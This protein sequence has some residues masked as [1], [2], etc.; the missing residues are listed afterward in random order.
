M[1][2]GG[3]RAGAGRPSKPLVDKILERNPGK[4]PLTVLECPDTYKEETLFI[5]PESLSEQGKEIFN[6][7]FEWLI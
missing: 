6:N 2:R 1:A 7:T 4:H 3:K 5:P